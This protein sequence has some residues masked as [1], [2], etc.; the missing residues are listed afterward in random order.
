[1]D[2]QV[3]HTVKPVHACPD[4]HL[5][6]FTFKEA[7]NLD[8]FQERHCIRIAPE[9]TDEKPLAGTYEEVVFRNAQYRRIRDGR[10]PHEGSFAR[11][12]IPLK[13]GIPLDKPHHASIFYGRL[14]CIPEG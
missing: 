3:A 12:H 6:V 1:M 5:F 10:F 2:F 7:V 9:A 13:N 11:L 8:T 14:R 4:P